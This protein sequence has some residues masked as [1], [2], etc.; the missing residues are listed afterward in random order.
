MI[1]IDELL[2][3]SKRL[4]RRVSVTLEDHREFA[5]VD[6]SCGVDLL[7]RHVGAVAARQ[8]DIRGGAGDRTEGTD[9]YAVR[10]DSG[11]VGTRLAREGEKSGGRTEQA[12]KPLPKHHILPYV[13]SD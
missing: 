7:D 12:T 13:F 1:L 5:A 2:H 9:R 3:R 6:A 10:R 4:G 11:L 8:A